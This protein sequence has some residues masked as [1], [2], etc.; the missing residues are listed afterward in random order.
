MGN[1]TFG[2]L[3]I[4]W[5]NL[6]GRHSGIYDINRKSSTKLTEQGSKNSALGMKE[7]LFKLFSIFRA[8]AYL[9]DIP[10][11]L[12]CT[13]CTIRLIRQALEWS[14]R[15]LFWSCADVDIVQP[16]KYREDCFGHGKPNAGRCRCDRLYY[17]ETFFRIKVFRIYW[18]IR[19]KI[20]TISQ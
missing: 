6:N 10:N 12:E 7:D 19:K 1:G 3:L 5:R 8:Q 14:E 16:G 9:I 20:K 13:N 4:I 11:D 18:C 15:Y 17:G 2:T